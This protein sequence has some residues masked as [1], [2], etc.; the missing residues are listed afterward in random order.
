MRTPDLQRNLGES[1]PLTNAAGP[2]GAR[3]DGEARVSRAV[4]SLDRLLSMMARWWDGWT[5]ARIAREHRLTRQ[6][7]ASLLAEVGC[8]RARWCRADHERTDSRRRAMPATVREARAAL[9]HPLAHRLTVRQR[10]ALAW[11]ALGLASPDI[12]RRMLT[13]PQNVRH[14]QIAAYRRLKRLEHARH[15]KAVRES[16]RSRSADAARSAEG[17]DI[18]VEWRDLFTDLN[19]S[20]RNTVLATEET[21]RPGGQG[22]CETEGC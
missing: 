19:G 1:A 16:R 21:P 5:T 8:T 2:H 15:E 3:A 20:S 22:A 6:R 14:F 10:A 9:L 17:D 13:T 7:A 12:A 4:A 18:R 11:R